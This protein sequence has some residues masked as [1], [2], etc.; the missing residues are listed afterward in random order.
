VIG[1]ARTQLLQAGAAIA[2]PCPHHAACPLSGDDWC[3]FAQRVAR[4]AFQRRLKGADAPFEDEKYSYLAVTRLPVRPP[5]A[6]ILRR[7]ETAAGHI[8]LTLCS[9]DGLQQT[10]VTRSQREAW[11]AA[12]DCD[13]GDGWT[14]PD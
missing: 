10:T 13:W 9:A 4:P 6:R 11:R 14:A 1:A 5:A 2:A 12:R 3:H 8:R 7:P